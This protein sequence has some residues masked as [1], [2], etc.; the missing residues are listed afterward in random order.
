MLPEERRKQLDGIVQQMTTNKE[1][2]QTIQLVVNDFKTKYSNEVQATPQKKDVLGQAT[3]V[4]NT[5]FP[6]KQVGE[7]IGTL[8]GLGLAKLKGTSEFYDTSA[9]SPL[10]V[11]GDI[12]QGALTVAAPGV[13][14]GRSVGGRILANTALGGGIGATGAVAQGEQGKGILEAG[15]IGAITGLTLS[16]GAEAVSALSK[17][18]P[19]WLTKSALP[20]LD[21]K[22][23][24]YALENTKLGSTRSMLDDS[25][26][27]TQRYEGQVQ[28]VLKKPEYIYNL[29]DGPG[30]LFGAVEELPQANLDPMK[31][32]KIAAKTV[33]EAEKLILKVAH[34]AATIPE[35]NELRKLLDPKIK[36]IFTDAPDVSFNKKV[37]A[38]FS[39]S[40]RNEVKGIAYETEP[41]FE[42]YTKELGL[43][44]ALKVLNNKNKLQP[45]PLDLI[46][47]FG[48]YMA[49]GWK[50]AAQAIAAERIG[51]SP[52]FKLGAAKAINSTA[53]TLAPALNAVGKATTAT[54]FK[55]VTE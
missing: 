41:I 28:S 15:A 3:K 21:N 40:L 13:G 25:I 32:A 18:L 4:F 30:A 31:V 24:N 20:K 44:A 7:A 6:G 27:N 8:G 14:T 16:T 33:P 38:A 37:V 47:G 17:S 5:V 49:G 1:S 12:A 2:D 48:G 35:K 46:T 19:L 52:A 34:G 55:S 43:Q 36:K 10:Q 54:L 11:A 22:N 9:P 42:E 53:K 45:T 23:L 50:G 29:G 51:N 26:K 39:N